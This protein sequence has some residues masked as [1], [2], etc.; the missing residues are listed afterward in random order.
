MTQAAQTESAE[1]SIRA[2][3]HWR[4]IPAGKNRV[5]K[6]ASSFNPRPPS[7]AGDPVPPLYGR[8]NS[9]FQS[10][11]AITG[12]RSLVVP[13]LVLLVLGFNPRPPSLAG[14][15]SRPCAVRRPVRCFNPRPPSLAGD[16]FTVTHN[17]ATQLVSIRAR[18]HWRAIR[19]SRCVS[20]SSTPFQS[21]PAIT[22]GRSI[23]RFALSL[24]IARFNPRPPSLAGDPERND[25]PQE[26]HKRFNPRPPSLAGD[27]RGIWIVD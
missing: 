5:S 12:G 17:T 16:P 22:G 13:L 27:P 6:R 26:G 23:A 10:A 2:R 25:S 11:P 1:V 8:R 21:A 20:T 18:H 9:R 7:L 24:Q 19:P 14:D 3:H 15:P 4:A